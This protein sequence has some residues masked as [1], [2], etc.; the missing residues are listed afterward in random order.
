MNTTAS[1]TATTTGSSTATTTAVDN[2][3]SRT[4]E[5]ALTAQQ[6]ETVARSTIAGEASDLAEL[7]ARAI[8]ETTTGEF[9]RLPMPATTRRKSAWRDDLT[10]SP[11][12]ERE[13]L[14]EF[15]LEPSMGRA[16]EMA[17]GEVLRLEQIEGSQCLDFNCFSLA[18]Y[19]EAFHTGRTRTLHGINPTTGDFLWSA[20][21]RERAMMFILADSVGCNDVLFP[22]CSANMYESVYGFTRHTNCADIQAEAQREYGLTPDDVHDSFNLFM[23]TEVVDG[24]PRIRR[25]DTAPGD[26]V[27]LLAVMDV[28]AVPNICGSDVQ[29]TSNYSLKPVLVQ[30]FRASEADLAAVPDLWEYDSQRAPADFTQPR[31]RTE[32]AL[33]RDPSYVPAFLTDAVGTGGEAVERDPEAAA[34]FERMWDDGLSARYGARGAGL[35][36]VLF[37]WWAAT[38]GH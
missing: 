10:T 24:M 6:Q 17:A 12:I 37:S 13:L 14:E 29:P 3:P 21:P 27:E 30:R 1:S 16:I 18:D 19:R 20:P 23:S 36:D 9:S 7:A 31:I 38:H 26:H 15:V 34:L 25:Q 8:R 11:G 22:R 32:R 35:R 2:A 5:L 33:H 4:I 28:L